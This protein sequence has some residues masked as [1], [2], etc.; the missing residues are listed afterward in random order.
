VKYH[1]PL[2]GLRESELEVED[3]KVEGC[4]VTIIARN[5]SAV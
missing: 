2:I 3:T 5:G 4:A 1:K